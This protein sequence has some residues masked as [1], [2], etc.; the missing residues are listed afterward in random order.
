MVFH[1]FSPKTEDT[2]GHQRMWHGFLDGFI[3]V[4]HGGIVHMHLVRKALQEFA[5]AHLNGITPV[6]YV[7]HVPTENKNVEVWSHVDLFDAI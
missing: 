2:R 5:R 3:P 6:S 4:A 1:G 7:M